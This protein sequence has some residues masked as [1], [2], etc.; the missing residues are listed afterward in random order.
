MHGS[1]VVAV[2][3][4]VIVV[5]NTKHTKFNITPSSSVLNH[6]VKHIKWGTSGAQPNKHACKLQLNTPNS[7][8]KPC[9]NRHMDR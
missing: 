2:V 9:Q 8:L 4:V 1:V 7:N 6:C 3:V 5:G